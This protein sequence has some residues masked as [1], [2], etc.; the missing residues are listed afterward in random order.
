MNGGTLHASNCTFDYNTAQLTTAADGAFDYFA[1]GGGAA[2]MNV[3]DSSLTNCTFANNAVTSAMG[4]E[5]GSSATAIG[6]GLGIAMDGDL[7]LLN[8]TFANNVAGG[9]GAD[10]F[11]GGFGVFSFGT[12]SM[13]G[14]S[15][16]KVANTAFAGNT[17][18]VGT[19]AFGLDVSGWAVANLKN[20]LIS[21]ADDS[22]ITVG[23]NGNRGGTAA[24]PLD[25]KLGTLQNNGGV[26]PT[27]MP[28]TGSPLL[29]NASASES[30]R[31]DARGYPR[32]PS[33]DIGAVEKQSNYSPGLVVWPDDIAQADTPFVTSIAATDVDGD[34]ITYSLTQAPLGCRWSITVTA[35]RR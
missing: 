4:S 5:A 31:T 27:M 8:C 25:A 19:D 9:N 7:T 1:L 35:R 2:L 20:N 30:P 6:A 13:D 17:A 21:I 23:S 16:L 15:T 34:A 12:G 29:G 32:S 33:Y 18:T 10:S 22:G 3:D 26:V 11:G 28:D 24:A 14:Q